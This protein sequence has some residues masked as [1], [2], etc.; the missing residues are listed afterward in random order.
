M[1]SVLGMSHDD[2]VNE[3]MR[4]FVFSLEYLKKHMLL[5]GQVEN[6]VSILDTNH[7]GM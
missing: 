2:F 7:I 5:P 4:A 6:W 1:H 3:I